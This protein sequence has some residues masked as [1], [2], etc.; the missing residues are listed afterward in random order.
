MAKRKK[1]WESPTTKS[2]ESTR[3]PRVQVA[4]DTPLESFQQGLQYRFKPHLDWRST[5]EVII[6]QS[7]K[8]F[9]LGDFGTPTWESRDKKPF[10]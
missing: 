4:C 8:S 7:C 9:N 6:S 2:Q 1:E 10:G 3:F 5:K